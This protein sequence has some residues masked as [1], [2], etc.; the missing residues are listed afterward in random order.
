M[1]ER[2]WVQQQRGGS[3]GPWHLLHPGR[4]YGSNTTVMCGTGITIYQIGRRTAK[5]ADVGDVPRCAKCIAK[6]Y[7]EMHLHFWIDALGDDTG[8]QIW[9]DEHCARDLK[10]GDSTC[11]LK[12][13]I[14]T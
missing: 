13:I 9:G 11:P 3:W 5:E 10:S 14:Y 2:Q 8:H 7:P 1:R 12:A 6:P 4:P